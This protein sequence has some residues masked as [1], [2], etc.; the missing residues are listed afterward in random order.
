MV[1]PSGVDIQVYP[2]F[3]LEDYKPIKAV[4]P[5]LQ[6]FGEHKAPWKIAQ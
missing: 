3:Q 4:Q 2:L 5:V 1:V 6:A